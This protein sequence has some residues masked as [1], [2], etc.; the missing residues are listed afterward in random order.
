M[1]KIR[2]DKEEGAEST[3]GT[4]QCGGL[5]VYMSQTTHPRLHV[6]L[7]MSNSKRCK[8]KSV[9]ITA[10]NKVRTRRLSVSCS[11][12]IA[13]S[14]YWCGSKSP[15]TGRTT[16]PPSSPL[17]PPPLLRPHLKPLA[18]HTEVCAARDHKVN[19]ARK[20]CVDGRQGRSKRVNPTRLSS[21]RQTTEIKARTTNTRVVARRGRG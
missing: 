10:G 18:R 8:Q 5:L 12:E 2:K 21:W 13:S 14:K 19:R 11:S 1:S 9:H 16:A 20:S 6:P 3:C 7:L 17:F 4:S 15:T